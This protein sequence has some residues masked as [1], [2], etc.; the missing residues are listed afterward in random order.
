MTKT[1]LP[2]GS[3]LENTY[4]AAHRLTAITDNAGNKIQY[5]LDLAGN[6]TAEQV[7]DPGGVLKR[8]LART[9][10]SLSQLTQTVAG[11]GQTTTF[12][13]DA[14]G[15]PTTTTLDPAGLNQ[16]TTQAFDALNRV[17]TTTQ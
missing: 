16:A 6:R 8:T 11:A 14:N 4:D 7:K 10:N 17:T 1:T 5:T 2:D 12:A 13:Y 3:F 9:Y 15:N